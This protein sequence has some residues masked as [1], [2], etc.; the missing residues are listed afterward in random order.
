MSETNATQS[1]PNL[2]KA[3]RAKK[4]TITRVCGKLPSMK[5]TD[6]K[7]WHADFYCYVTGTKAEDSE[8]GEYTR[9]L[10]EFQSVNLAT[11]EV[12]KSANAIFPPIA[13]GMIEAAYVGA[14]KG[15]SADNIMLAF[16][17]GTEPDYLENGMPANRTGY[18]YIIQDIVTASNRTPLDLLYEA[19]HKPLLTIEGDKPKLITGDAPT[20]NDPDAVD[21][22]DVAGKSPARGRSKA[23]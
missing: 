19:A 7:V 22:Q 2:S 16:R 14:N 11:G 21:G 8:Y 1:G 3:E 23:A 4:L 13:S 12:L 17:I 20:S 10:G 9:W 5:A 6:G 18:R 15:A